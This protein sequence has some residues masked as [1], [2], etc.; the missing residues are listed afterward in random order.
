MSPPPSLFDLEGVGVINLAMGRYQERN[1][2][3]SI[4]DSQLITREVEGESDSGGGGEREGGR[5]VEGESDSGGG[6]E[7]EGGREGE[8]DL[9]CHVRIYLN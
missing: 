2:T 5:E 9:G 1:S 6:G 3:A 4:T 8:S 7:R